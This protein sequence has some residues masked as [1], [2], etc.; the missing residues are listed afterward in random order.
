M[1]PKPNKK[2]VK[3]MFIESFLQAMLEIVFIPL[4]ISR[5]PLRRG[6]IKDVLIFSKLNKGESNKLTP[7]KI[8]LD[9]RIEIILE[10]ITTNPPIRKI[11]ETLL[12][13]LLAKTSPKLLKETY[14]FS[15]L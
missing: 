14:L 4:V 2:A 1:P 13:I 15:G 10:K 6:A 12:V 7:F 9:F 3:R 8:P 11:V 5:N